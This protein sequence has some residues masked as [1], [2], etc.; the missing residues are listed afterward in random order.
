[1]EKTIDN[2]FRLFDKGWA[3]VTSGSIDDFNTMTVSWGSLG[4]LWS[5]SIVT[6]YIKP[7]RYTHQFMEKNDHFTV[8]FF[9]EQFREDLALLGSKSG[10]DGN[11][12]AETSLEPVSMD[13]TVGF[14]QARVTIICRKIYHSD[15]DPE[16]I[17]ASAMEKYYQSEAPH[18]MYIGE[19]EKI[20]CR[21][22]DNA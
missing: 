19:V 17:P 6:V 8:S 16:I 11:K 21:Q 14:R 15:F 4:T 2:M 20:I 22:E 9:D 10:R 5:R 1:M 13:G 12:V 3:L 18:T 7:C